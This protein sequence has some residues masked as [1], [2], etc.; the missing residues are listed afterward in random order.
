MKTMKEK[1]FFLFSFLLFFFQ[2]FISFCLS[3]NLTQRNFKGY[4]YEPYPL[5]KGTLLLQLGGSFTL[6]PIP[7]AENEIIVPT[8]DLQSKYAFNRNFCLTSSLF[9]NFFSNAL[10]T[11]IQFNEKLENFSFGISNNIGIFVGFVNIEGQFD[12]NTAIVFFYLPT[13]KTGYRFDDFSFS[14]NFGA[15]YI[16]Y[17][18]TKISEVN[19]FGISQSWNMFYTT[20]AVEQPIFKK[21]YISFG[22][23][24]DYSK[25]PYQSWLMY[26]TIDNK[27]FIPEFFFSFQL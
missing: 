24:I 21:S 25:S 10:Q 13:F 15:N 2:D 20:F 6:L 16:L 7:V 9:T 3:D 19:A 18:Q 4:F 12:N 11:G 22:I 8:L 17:G 23:S 26:N 14:I 27:M 1:I 5:E